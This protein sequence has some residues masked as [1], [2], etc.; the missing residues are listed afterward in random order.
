MLEISKTTAFGLAFAA[1]MSVGNGAYAATCT[2]TAVTLTQIETSA[3]PVS[4]LYGS[5]APAIPSTT[6]YVS[7]GNDTG[8]LN[9]DANIGQAGDGLLNGEGGFDPTVLVP[10]SYYLDIDGNGS[11]L[12]PG[13]IRLGGAEAGGAVDYQSV[14]NLNGIKK[15]TSDFLTLGYTQGDNKKSGTWSLDTKVNSVELVQDFLGRSTFDHLAV[16]LKAGNNYA[17]YDF[18]FNLMTLPLGFN[19]LT[20]YSFDGTWATTDL[21]NNGGNQAELSH[22]SFWARDPSSP[23]NQ[24]PEPATLVL[25]GVG[26]LGLGFSRRRRH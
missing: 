18:D 5:P 1:L 10:T 9:P 2:N 23:A 26:L 25:I 16:I 17:I 8:N 7:S 13:W 19:F 20:A 4:V 11:Y 24:V 3:A 14:T 15:Q 6:C 22:I 21:I 12:D